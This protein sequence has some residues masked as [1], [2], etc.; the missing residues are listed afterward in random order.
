MTF[1]CFVF[2]ALSNKIG[3]KWVL[4]IGTL[5][6]APYSASLYVN[7]RY[8]VEWFVIFGGAT[9]GIAAAALWSSEAA[10]ALGYGKIEDRG[11]FSTS[12]PRHVTLSYSAE[13]TQFV[14]FAAGLW[15][16]LRELGQLI[17]ASIQLAYNAKNSNSGKVS[18]TTYFILIALQCLGLP[19]ALLVSPPHKVVRSDGER[20]ADPTKNKKTSVEL[21]KTWALLKRK[22]ILL[23]VPILVGFQWNSVYIGIYLTK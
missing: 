18:Y 3:V 1:L 9:C 10:I 14:L 4:V 2:G 23:M 17:G 6:Y 12:F 21:R 15:L 22:E 16:G 11:K 20:L 5:G 19:L 7:N 13:L 8:G